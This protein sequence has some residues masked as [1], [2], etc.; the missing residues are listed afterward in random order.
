MVKVNMALVKKVTKKKKK[1]SK[2]GSKKGSNPFDDI[3]AMGVIPEVGT[4][5]AKTG[6]SGIQLPKTLSKGSKAAVVQNVCAL[7]NPFCDRAFGQKWPDADGAITIPYTYHYNTVVTSAAANNV[8]FG[9]MADWLYGQ[10]SATAAAGNFTVPANWTA[11]TA[12]S[13]ANSY[14]VVGRVVS[15]GVI[16]RVT[17][18]AT[19]TQ[20]YIIIKETT[21]INP[22]ATVAAG[23]IPQGANSKIMALAPGVEFSFAC[24]PLGPGAR[25][26]H[27]LLA[28]TSSSALSDWTAGW[29]ELA[30]GVATTTVAFECFVHCELQLDIN[31]TLYATT[32]PTNSAPRIVDAA[33]K[34]YQNV[35]VVHTSRGGNLAA[36]LDTHIQ[37]VASRVV[38]GFLA[39]PMGWGMA[40]LS[41]LGI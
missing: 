35:D 17:S 1:G 39:D 16:G 26:Y 28:N 10:N 37:N 18:N 32:S 8:M 25:D 21:S 9:F 20:G 31:S 22:G 13:A 14:G 36:T 4:R 19:N 38:D 6:A 29:F 30:T 23:I 3:L 34:T 5:A 12:V 7:T 15:A 24:R 33:S 40:A 27:A 11:H 2:P 41:V